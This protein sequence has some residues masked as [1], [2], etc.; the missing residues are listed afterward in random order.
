MD[1]RYAHF[2]RVLF[3]LPNSVA[4][5]CSYHDTCN[6]FLICIKTSGYTAAKPLSECILSYYIFLKILWPS[7]HRPNPAILLY[8]HGFI[9]ALFIRTPI[10]RRRSEGP[11]E[12]ASNPFRRAHQHI[13]ILCITLSLLSLVHCSIIPQNTLS[14]ELACIM[15]PQAASFID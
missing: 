5:P 3:S 11:L 6:C 4:F 7:S 12:S 10:S 8:Q 1:L 13:H 14:K 9:H 2:A 15:F